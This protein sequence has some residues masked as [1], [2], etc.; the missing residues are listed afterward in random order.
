[1]VGSSTNLPVAGNPESQLFV[2]KL[3][4]PIILSGS[5]AGDAY[6]LSV[7]GAAGRTLTV[8]AA[9]NLAHWTTLT[10]FTGTNLTDA[11]VVPRQSEVG[12][13]FFRVTTP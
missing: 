12:G 13:Q 6:R 11:L 3:A 5:P 9:T 8:Q 1:M 10:N 7:S 2:A 4:P